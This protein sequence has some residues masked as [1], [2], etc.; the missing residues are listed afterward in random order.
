MYRTRAIITR[1]RFE[2]A[3]DY[4]PRIFKI[5]KV[6]LNHKPLCNIN[7]GLYSIGII[8]NISFE[9][10]IATLQL[11]TAVYTAE[12]FII[13]WNF[14]CLKNLR[15]IIES[16]FK[17]RAGYNGARTVCAKSAFFREIVMRTR[18]P[19]GNGNF[20]PG[21]NLAR[22][23]ITIFPRVTSENDDFTEKK[24]KGIEICRWPSHI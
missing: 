17:S 21:K 6:S 24:W 8:R 12:R 18:H 22:G 7:R 16:G 10:F 2:T 1:S 9:D 14:F 4:K 3:L 19:G 11:Q 5:R 13:Q 23:E 15:F 20:S